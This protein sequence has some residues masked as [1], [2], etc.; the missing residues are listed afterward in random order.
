MYID[1]KILLDSAGDD[2]IAA[3]YNTQVSCC[4][5]EVGSKGLRDLWDDGIRIIGLRLYLDQ[6]KHHRMRV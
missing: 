4:C 1:C 3:K 5:H 6:P 2:S